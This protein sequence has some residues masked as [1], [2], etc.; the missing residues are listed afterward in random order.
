M[1]PADIVA[2]FVFES[3]LYVV[4]ATGQI[5]RWDEQNVTWERISLLRNGS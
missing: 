1:G 5:W 4:T 3:Y 2:S